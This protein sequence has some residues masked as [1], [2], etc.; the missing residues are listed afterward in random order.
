MSKLV[1][2]P[3][4]SHSD[5][6]ISD[7]LFGPKKWATAFKEFGFR[8]SALTDHGSMANIIPLYNMMKQNGQT[9]I[10]GC[11]FYYV[12][13]PLD[14]T[15]DNRKNSHLIL[16]A[17]NYEGF[18]NLLKLMNLSYSEGYYYKNR[19]GLEWLAKYSENLVCLT[20]CQGGVLA[21][22]VWR[23]KKGQECIGLENKFLELQSIFGKDL[24]VEFQGH[25]T[26]NY[27]ETTK[28]LFCSQ[29]M[30]N[31]A[32]YDKLR[33]MKGFQPILTNDS[34][35]ILPEHAKIQRVMK[36]MAYGKADV[37]E[38]AT[39]TKDHFT[40]SLWLKNHK[41]VYEAFRTNHEYLPKEFVVESM[42]ATVEVFEKCKDFA[43][44]KGKR[45]L[46]AYTPTKID[47]DTYSETD[48][49][50]FFKA[51]AISQ[52][53]NM[54]KAGVLCH[55]TKMEYM[56]RFKKEYDV[57]S[58]YG[59]EDYFLIVWDLIRYAKENNIYT[60]LGR[61]SAA[62]CLISYLLDIVKI[63][64]LEHGLIFERF[65]N[66]VRCESGELPDID[67]DFESLHRNQIKRYVF[68]TYGKDKVCDIGTYGRMKLKTSLL[69][70]GKAFGAGTHK[71]L[72]DITKNLDLDK[73]DVDDLQS[74][75][76]QDPRL[77]RLMLENPDYD[78]AVRECIG[79]IKSQGIH[80]AG[81]IICSEPI[82]H[83]TPLKSQLKKKTDEFDEVDSDGEKRVMATQTEDKYVIAQGLMKVDILGIKQY[84]IIKYVIENADTGFTRD[85]YVTGIMGLERE[86]PNRKIWK[87]FQQG[88]TDGVFQFSSS[89]MQELLV[90]MKPEQISD[91]IA[92]N[93][94]YR[95]GCLENG[96]HTDYCNRKN[97]LESVSYIHED[98]EKTLSETY[99]IIVYQ[100][101]FMEVFNKIGGI[102]LS[103]SD[104]I[105]SALGKKDKEKLGKFRDEFIEGASKK[106]SEE[107]ADELWHQIEKAS[108]YSFNKSHSAAYGVLAYITQYLK[109]YHTSHFWCASLQ[110][111]VIKKKEDELSQ[112]RMASISMGVRHRL[113]EINTSK[114]NFSVTEDGTIVWGFLSVNGV[115]PQA[116]KDLE[117]LQPYLSFDDF[118]TK[119]KKSKIKKNNIEGL[120]Q[121]GAFDSFG[122][123]RD[124]LARIH[125]TK[126]KK[127]KTEKPFM[128]LSEVDLITK[129]R[130][131]MGFFE[132]QI[133]RARPG[134][135]RHCV[136]Q[137][138]VEGYDAG[139][140]VRIGG[141]ATNVSI[142]RTKKG[143]N[144][145]FI[146]IEDMDETLE[147]TCF[148][149]TY[150]DFKEYIKKGNILEIQGTKSGFNGKTNCVEASFVEIK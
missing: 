35:Y 136:T 61:G 110:W 25:K 26:P 126:S 137:K 99:G 81:L 91:L 50:R 88:K 129:F 46:P 8:A 144:M 45:Y 47:S 51:I 132:Q 122:D 67:T 4:H 149:N 19:I 27:D 130:D 21:N 38:S 40:D 13:N 118:M 133:K 100:E 90:M 142:I 92:A 5:A 65:L 59:L 121:A 105:R 43:F 83:V 108:G 131:S 127:I 148:P 55:A 93:A 72:L 42:L 68:D 2:V 53:N 82:A 96:W 89:G 134:F 48:S 128:P 63:D 125:D 31:R 75:I 102:P 95:P 84:D 114:E 74:A 14:K 9:L 107:E 62:G 20:A 49:K 24:Y 150:R 145:C 16:L 141:I 117:R 58:K 44:P 12:D 120:I 52:F 37:G 36:E 56:A 111:A 73:E 140:A 97:G 143:D 6:S 34:H 113:P 124:L 85:N 3:L 54:W 11:E 123:R 76:E 32:F 29:E 70:F 10:V 23:K 22:Q 103:Q 104:I 138:D 28:E 146:T 33:K 94:L 101:Q 79:Q 30:I 77:E 86:K 135:S 18:Q 139:D 98:V 41:Q 66:E 87:M 60:G 116:A 1:Y 115:G 147:V 39:V 15:S 57:I 78:W 17:K 7:G 112:M 64:P 69:D 109:V 80:P 119:I 106:I 71:E